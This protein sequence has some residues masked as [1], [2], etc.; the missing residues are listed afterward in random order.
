MVTLLMLHTFG[1]TRYAIRHS[2]AASTNV[3]A[4]HSDFGISLIIRPPQAVSLPW[5]CGNSAYPAGSST[6]KIAQVDAGGY[7]WLLVGDWHSMSVQHVD[8]TC[9]VGAELTTRPTAPEVGV[10]AATQLIQLR[11]SATSGFDPHSQRPL[12]ANVN[13]LSR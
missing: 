3:E 4:A 6:A 2:M 12:G 10:N 8:L 9:V 11:N 13:C 1:T 7:G 5:T